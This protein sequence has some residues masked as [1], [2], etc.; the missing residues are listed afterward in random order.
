MKTLQPK[1]CKIYKFCRKIESTCNL[2]ILYIIIYIRDREY[3]Y[4]SLGSLKTEIWP[5]YV[6]VY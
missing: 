3:N 2:Y 5:F 4:V 1:Y 6:Y